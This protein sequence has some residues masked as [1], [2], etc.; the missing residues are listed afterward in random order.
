MNQHDIY[1][2]KINLERLAMRKYGNTISHE[3][4]SKIWGT[5]NREKTKSSK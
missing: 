2:L 1:Q 4:K 5:I 3:A